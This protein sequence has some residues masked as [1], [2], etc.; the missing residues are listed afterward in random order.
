MQLPSVDVFIG[1]FFLLGLAYGFLL[2]REKTITALCSVYIGLV[3]ASSFSGSIFDLMNGN[4]VIAN[5]IWQRFL[6]HN[7]YHRLP[8]LDILGF[9]R[10][11]FQSQKIKWRS[12]DLGNINL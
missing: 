7:R 4:K 3:I 9:R 5:Q 6:L 1:I 8:S 2:Q 10:N 12:L 11:K